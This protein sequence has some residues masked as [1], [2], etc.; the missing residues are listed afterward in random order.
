MS[1]EIQDQLRCQTLALTQLTCR[2]LTINEYNPQTTRDNIFEAESSPEMNTA[3]SNHMKVAAAVETLAVSDSREL[4][5]RDHIQVKIIE[6]LQYSLMRS[7][8][9]DVE[10]AYPNTCHWIFDTPAPDQL[11]GSSFGDWLRQGTGVYW[12]NGKAGSGKSTLMKYVYDD[13][14]TRR[15]LGMWTSDTPLSCGYVLLF[16]QRLK[17]TTFSN[18]SSPLSTLPSL[19]PDSR[20]LPSHNA[21]ALGRSI[22]SQCTTTAHFQFR[23]QLVVLATTDDKIQSIGSPRSDTPQN[24]FF[25][26]DG[27]DEFKGNMEK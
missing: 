14:R 24:I 1:S 25:S 15:Y 18:R 5:L 17:T 12:M 21:S 8:Y 20:A 3:T 4:K 26:F 10:D 19:D 23:N 16:E 2:L 13:D 27:L 6:G 11:S 22:Y 9:E 7:R